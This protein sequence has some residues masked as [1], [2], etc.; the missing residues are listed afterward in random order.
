MTAPTD[1]NLPVFVYGTLKHGHSN[2]GRFLQGYTR[3]ELPAVLP[4]AALFVADIIPYLVI[5]AQQYTAA[6]LVQGELME[7]DPA[8]YAAC[9]RGLDWL[10]GY[11]PAD[12]ASE[13][14]RITATVYTPDAAVTAWTYVAGTD[15]QAAIAAGHLHRLLDGRWLPPGGTTAIGRRFTAHDD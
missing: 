9:M 15:V 14:R 4:H 1:A 8:H 6:Y 5:D 10:E 3:R 7:L 13:Y 11:D 12:P 2:Y